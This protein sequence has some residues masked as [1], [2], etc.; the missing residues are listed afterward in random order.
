VWQRDGKELFYVAAD[1][2]LMSVPVKTALAFEAGPPAALFR[3]DPS[4]G[5]GFYDVTPDGQRFLVNTSVTRAESLPIT[6]VVNWTA[7]L[8]LTRPR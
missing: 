6:A 2:K 7:A 3:I 5:G 4:G 8:N 1:N